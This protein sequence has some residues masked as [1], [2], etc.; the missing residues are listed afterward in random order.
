MNLII[1]AMGADMYRTSDWRWLLYRTE[2]DRWEVSELS[3]VRQRNLPNLAAA[4]HWLQSHLE[5]GKEG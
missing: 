3:L 2:G 5:N 4:K 1:T